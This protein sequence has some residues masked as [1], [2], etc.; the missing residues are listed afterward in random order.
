MKEDCFILFHQNIFLNIL[1]IMLI[2]S[3]IYKENKNKIL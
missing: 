2:E 1:F 3:R